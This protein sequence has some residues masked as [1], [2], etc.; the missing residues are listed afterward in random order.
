MLDPARFQ[1]N[2][3]TSDQVEKEMWNSK[4]PYY[5][6]LRRVKSYFRWTRAPQGQIFYLEKLK[7]YTLIWSKCFY[8]R[9]VFMKQNPHFS[10]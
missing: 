2:K 3:Q 1:Q 9:L 4:E 8:L 6:V 10:F 5:T 7:I